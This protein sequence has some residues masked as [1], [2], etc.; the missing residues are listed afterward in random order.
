MTLVILL[1]SNSKSHQDR[2]RYWVVKL[3]EAFRSMFFDG[4]ATTHARVRQKT[5]YTWSPAECS[6]GVACEAAGVTSESSC[7]QNP[8]VVLGRQGIQ[9]SI[10]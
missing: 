1:C 10:P 2:S 3:E 7:S 5:M 6:S 4:Q 8:I 9:E